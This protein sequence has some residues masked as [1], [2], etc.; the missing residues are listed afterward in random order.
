MQPKHTRIAIMIFCLTVSL[1]GGLVTLI[2]VNTPKMETMQLGTAFRLTDDRGQPITEAALKGQPTLLFF[3][4]THCPEVCPTTL[5]EMAGWF[6]SLGSEADGLKAFFFSVDPERDTPEL[7]HN[8]TSAFTDRITGVTG[9]PSEMQD[10]IKSWN[11]YAKKVPTDDG[12]YTMDHTASVL[13]LTEKGDLKGTIS[14][15][16]TQETAVAK[17]RDLLGKN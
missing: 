9:D 1:F 7:M 15:G 16:S 2:V 8:Y 3:G 13:L 14:Y 6:K 5:Y 11:I 12:D 4:F 17:I 10:V